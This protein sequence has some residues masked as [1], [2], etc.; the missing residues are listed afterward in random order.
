ML[1]ETCYMKLNWV[2]NS[3]LWKWRGGRGG[4]GLGRGVGLGGQNIENMIWHHSFKCSK[5]SRAT[6][7]NCGGNSY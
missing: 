4:G 1:H 5:C 7:N 3:V 6:Y 2:K